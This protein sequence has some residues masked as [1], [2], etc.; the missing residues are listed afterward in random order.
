MAYTTGNAAVDEVL[1]TWLNKKFVTDLMFDLQWQKFT[2][3]AL[4]P[5]DQG[6][7]A[8]YIEFAPPGRNSSYS[9]Q[10]NT[11]MSE[12]MTNFN[13]ATSL[14]EITGITTLRTEVTVFEFGEH[15]KVGSLY[16][17]AS[18][19]GTKEK[20]VKRL[21]DGAAVSLDDV[22]RAQ[23]NLTTY[24]IVAD[25]TSVSGLF[26]GGTPVITTIPSATANKLGAAAIVAAKNILRAGLVPGIEGRAGHLS[27]NY[28]LII[29][30]SQET[31]IVTEVSTGRIYWSNCVV[32]VPGTMGQEKFV[33]GYLGDIYGTSC[34]T[35]QNFAT[36]TFTSTVS[37]GYI[38]GA[39]AVAA[40]AFRQM[41]P[42][43]IMN[44]VNSP[45][46]NVNS[47]AW[48]AQFGAGI[49]GAAAGLSN[50]VI[51]IYSSA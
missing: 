48:Y 22:V 21:K 27:G 32:N 38:M 44:E 10:G 31:Q 37:V 46:K 3:D 36:A 20:V 40:V 34:Y 6:A 12:A 26:G 50:R 42:Q 7:C 11:Q 25:D 28:A 47:V 9:S 45:Y 18:M 43:V 17:F 13:T 49:V 29:T 2:A 51:K 24:A 35:T 33:K 41:D 39:D 15:L 30:P 14:H 8:R 23:A 5:E 16:D 4:I 19:P 1:N